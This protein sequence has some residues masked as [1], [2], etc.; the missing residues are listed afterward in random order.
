LDQVFF[1]FRYQRSISG[2]RGTALT[3]PKTTSGSVN[4][5]SVS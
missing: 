4:S 2:P 5:G 3:L 1:Q